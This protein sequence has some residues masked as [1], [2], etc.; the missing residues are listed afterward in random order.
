MPK[1]KKAPVGEG[2][3]MKSEKKAPDLQEKIRVDGEIKHRENKYYLSLS[4]KYRT[5]GFLLFLIFVVFCGVMMLRYNEYVTYDN[6]VYLIR[7]FDSV[8]ES[9]RE[10]ETEIAL[11]VSEASVIDRFRDGFAVVSRDDVTLYDKTG[12]ELVSE[13]EK[14]S[15]PAFVSSDKYLVAY[16]VGGSSYSVYNSITRVLSKKT[17]FPIISMSVSNTGAYI[18]TTESDEAKYVTEVYN[19][20]LTRTMSI[21][22]DKFVISSAIS[23]DGEYVAIASLSE[24]GA[25][26]AC[27]VSFYKAGQTEALKTQ[28]YVMSMPLML[29]GLG[30]GNFVLLADDAL[31][32][33][34][35]GGELISTCAV[36]GNGVSKFDAEQ[37]GCMLV[38]KENPI[39]SENRVYIF[40]GEGNIVYDKTVKERVQG[41]TLA[42]ETSDYMGYITTSD[43][44]FLITKDG[45]NIEYG[46]DG[47]VL[48][49]VDTDSGAYMFFDGRAKR[50]ELS[51][52]S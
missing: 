12:V 3:K 48:C 10:G 27:E 26:F 34:S 7:D 38:C 49:T 35:K 50:I 52:E 13:K 37:S 17:E 44:V 22:K 21:Y 16:D 28:V 29:D 46:T 6:F 45:E 4:E 40:D 32:F 15:Y 33:F 18:L 31:R 42:Y 30:D 43:S 11:N 2:E 47:A 1:R 23:D 39:G 51:I 9:D 19:S 8:N 24:V 20:T 14:F 41:A 5:A 25:D 36:S